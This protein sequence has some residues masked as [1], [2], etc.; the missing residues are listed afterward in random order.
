MNTSKDHHH[1]DTKIRQRYCKKENYRPISLI[2]IDLKILSKTLA[3]QIQQY[4]TKIIHHEKW[5]LPQG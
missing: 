1:P 2:N 5:N 3:N 4:I